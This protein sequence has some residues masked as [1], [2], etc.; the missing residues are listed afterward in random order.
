MYDTAGRN[1]EVLNIKV[2]DIRLSTKDSHAVLTGKGNKIRI[3]P[4]MREP[5]I[6]LIF[7]FEFSM[8]ERLQ[9]NFYSTLYKKRKERQCQLIMSQNL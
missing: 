4:L 7:I 2:S 1:Q 3:V 8:T 6:T 5:L 9:M